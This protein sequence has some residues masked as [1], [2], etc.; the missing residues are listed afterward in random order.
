M[1][2][3]ERMERDER[4]RFHRTLLCILFFLVIPCSLITQATANQNDIDSARLFVQGFYDWYVPLA[5]KEN[6]EPSS[7]IAI[8]TKGTLFS[9]ELR[10]ALREDAAAEAKANGYVVGLDFDPFL[11]SQD[12][13]DRYD[14]GKISRKD[15][16]YWVEVYGTRYGEKSAQ[17]DVIAELVHKDSKWMFVN[18]H[19]PESSEDLMQ[20][21]KSLR[22]S[23]MK[24]KK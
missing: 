23:R 5:K 20:I 6:R 14:V 15:D 24:R 4:M 2:R 19:Y 11:Y 12:P 13:S 16:R 10:L 3:G 7:D 18:F 8:R 21:L 9:T 17:P 22:D 1:E